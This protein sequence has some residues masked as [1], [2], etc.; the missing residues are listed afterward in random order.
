M[1]IWLLSA[2]LLVL[3]GLV[4]VLSSSLASGTETRSDRDSDSTLGLLTQSAGAPARLVPQ[5]LS[6]RPHDPRAFTQ[7]LVLHGGLLYES[8]GLYGESTLRE[9]DPW[10]GEVYRRLDLP[11]NLFAEG[12]A[13]VDDRLIQLTWV[14]GVAIEYD[15]ATFERQQQAQY[16]GEGWGLCYDGEKLVMTDGS[17]QLFFRDPTTFEVIGQVGVRRDTVPQRRLNEL[18]CV[19]DSVYANVWQTDEIVR[20][21]PRTGRVL[22]VIDASL[23]FPAEERRARAA[24][25]LNG[26]AYDPASETFLITGKLWPTIFEVRF[27]AAQ[28]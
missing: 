11:P 13:R 9:V 21:D 7:G 23:L 27:V 19:G 20:I 10:T 3:A 16:S 14:E 6:T 4:G 1:H 22:A 28:G 24:D 17:D 8:T 2:T 26:I 25:V 18:E 12:L 5:V 15:L